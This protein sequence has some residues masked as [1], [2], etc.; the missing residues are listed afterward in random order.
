[1]AKSYGKNIYPRSDNSRYQ[2]ERTI[3]KQNPSITDEE[4]VEKITTQER[5]RRKEMSKPNSRLRF[6]KLVDQAKWRAR[7]DNVSFSITVDDIIKLFT[8][9]DKCPVLGIPMYFN[10]GGN[11]PAE[12]SPSLD[13][14]VPKLGYTPSNITVISYRANAI[15]RDASLEELQALVSWMKK[16][17]AYA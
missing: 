17:R 6:R 15:K 16:R 7:R 12:N 8:E 4:V 13:R 9:G 2:R 3:R 5:W 14:L 11:G 1:M 10:F